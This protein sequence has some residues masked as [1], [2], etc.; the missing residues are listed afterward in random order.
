M[1]DSKRGVTTCWKHS[2]ARRFISQP[3]EIGIQA[4]DILRARG[5][6]Y[7]TTLD[8]LE[9]VLEFVDPA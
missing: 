4:G 7:V 2:T 5:R 3:D 1:T 8:E 6:Y 9:K